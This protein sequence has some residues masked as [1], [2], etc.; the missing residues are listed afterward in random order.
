VWK[1]CRDTSVD[2]DAQA[3]WSK[4]ARGPLPLEELGGRLRF[5]DREVVGCQRVLDSIAIDLAAR[6]R[7]RI[8]PVD[9]ARVVAATEGPAHPGALTH[10]SRGVHKLRAWTTHG[11]GVEID[12][13]TAEQALADPLPAP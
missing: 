9:W 13:A 7:D 6:L 11:W 2:E 1:Q 5:S 3:I 12:A 8:S 4:Q 10:P